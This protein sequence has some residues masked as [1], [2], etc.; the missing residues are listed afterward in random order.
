MGRSIFIH[1]YD[2][3]IVRVYADLGQATA[4]LAPAMLQAKI[5]A[6]GIVFSHNHPSVGFAVNAD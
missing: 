5:I 1:S 3:L 4:F 6:L 2:W